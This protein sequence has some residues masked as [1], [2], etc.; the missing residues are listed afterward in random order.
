MAHAKSNSPKADS[1]L[2]FEAQLL[3]DADFT[4]LNPLCM[5]DCGSESRRQDMH[6]KSG[7]PPDSNCAEVQLTIPVE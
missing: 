2:N 7:M 6:L 1:G 5:S 3:P 4:F